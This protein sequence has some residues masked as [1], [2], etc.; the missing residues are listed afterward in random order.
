M[1][2][3]FVDKKNI[4]NH[5]IIIDKASDVH[6][7]NKVL[8]LKENAVFD[9]SDSEEWEYRV[10]L[11]SISQVA[12]RAAIIDK[13]RFSREPDIDITLFQGIPKQGKMETIIQKCVELGVKGFIPVLTERSI[14]SRDG[15]KSDKKARWQ[16]IADEAVKQCRR[17]VIPE[18]GGVISV[19]QAADLF[20]TGGF[21]KIIF[22]YENAESRSIK[23]ALRGLK[24]KPKMLAVIIGPE[25]GFSEEEAG[26]LVAAGADAVTLGK[27]ILRTETAGPAAV[28]MIMYELEL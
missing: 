16:K 10:R 25:G 19:S 8:R 28:A 17:G 14:T 27:T 7:I 12:V 15:N 22:P 3:F 24:E 6:H 23:T 5:E 4:K 18:I 1:S 9:V 2:R 26:A 13:Q 11:T 20:R 21:D